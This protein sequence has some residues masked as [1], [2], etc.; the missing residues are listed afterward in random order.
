MLKLILPIALF[1]L[2]LFA[3]SS[4][5]DKG[6]VRG[7]GVRDVECAK[8]Q[9]MEEMLAYLDALRSPDGNLIINDFFVTQACISTW[10]ELCVTAPGCCVLTSTPE[11][12]WA[13]VSP[14]ELTFEIE[15]IKA[16]QDYVTVKG[17]AIFGVAAPVYRS[18]VLQSTFV[19]VPV[20]KCKWKISR[21]TALSQ[22]CQPNDLPCTK[23]G[24]TLSVL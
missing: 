18:Y 5:L 3:S 23:C 22:V 12:W 6:L 24:Y 10:A 17:T 1:I 8:K 2:P 20:S 19:W 15:E 13:M 11:Q 4:H 9:V 16:H 14:N 7:C 21:L